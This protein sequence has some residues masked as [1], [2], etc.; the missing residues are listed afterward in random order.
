MI[1]ILADLPLVPDGDAARQQAEQELSKTA[2]VEARPTLF[3]E[4]A[5]AIVDF[6]GTLFSP[7]G[8]EAL[9]PLALVIAGIVIV[10][11]LIAVL[12][13]WGRPRRSFTRRSA[14]GDLLGSSDGRSAAQLRDD[15]ESRARSRDWD[16]AIV[17]RYRALAR[18]LQERE[19]ISPAPGATAQRIAREASAPFPHEADALGAAA[20]WFDDVRYLRHPGTADRYRTLADTDDRLAN[21]RPVEVLV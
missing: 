11:A 12:I 21:T 18:A 13:I 10:G 7:R 15:A 4:W 16:E 8:G 5:R 6:L 2:Y 14:I 1:A 3:D 17:L 9:G 19:L 20:A